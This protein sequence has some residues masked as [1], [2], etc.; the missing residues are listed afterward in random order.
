MR[1]SGLMLCIVAA[2]GWATEAHSQQKVDLEEQTQVT[3]QSATA[4]VRKYPDGLDL[5]AV[6]EL[7]LPTAEALAA[8]RSHLALNGIR[9]LPPDV[10]SALAMSPASLELE[11]L[12]ELTSVPL[13]M[14]L[15]QRNATVRLRRVTRLDDQIADALASGPAF[16]VLPGLRELT[17]PGVAA[18]LWSP[19]DPIYLQ[20]IVCIR[21]EVA[22]SICRG[23]CDLYLQ[24]LE[25]LDDESAAA[26]AGGGGVRQLPA[27][28]EIS[29][30]GLAILLRTDGPLELG[31]I[32]NLA[33][34]GQRVSKEITQALATH[35]WP[36]GIGLK[37][38][39]PEVADAITKR[40]AQVDLYGLRHLSVGLAQSLVNSNCVIYMMNVKTAEK[41]VGDVLARHASKAGHVSGFVFAAS[42]RNEFTRDEI[43]LLKQRQCV[44]FGN[45]YN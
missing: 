38:I 14:K 36:L 15:G 28:R 24:S 30:Q 3:P 23:R 45:L 40:N 7:D 12:E 22:R 6:K 44:H 21:P 25:S 43:A 17:H 41:G 39:P 4:L 11:G 32:S 1:F 20:A 26:L 37:D 10:A 29:D 33:P 5:P 34:A 35:A 18:R 27:L 16:L 2:L 8:C 9:R 19:A 42:M 31:G 13:A